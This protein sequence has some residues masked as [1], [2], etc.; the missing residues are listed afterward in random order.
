MRQNGILGTTHLGKLMI[1]ILLLFSMGK[2]FV[3]TV[4]AKLSL[5]QT[6]T[7]GDTVQLGVRPGVQ[8]RLEGTVPLAIML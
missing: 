3:C 8:L 7:W 5:G 2:E 1:F 4:M 6:V